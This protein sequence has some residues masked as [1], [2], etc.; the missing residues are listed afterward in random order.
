MVLPSERFEICSEGGY[1]KLII[2]QVAL[3]DEGTYSVQVGEYS[4]SAKLTVEGKRV[5]D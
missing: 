1:R 4:C 2:Q 3:D 5:H